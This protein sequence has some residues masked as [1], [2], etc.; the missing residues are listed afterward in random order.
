MPRCC[1]ALAATAA[2]CALAPMPASAALRLRPC[3]PGTARQC[4]RLTVPLDRSG[5]VP[6]TV[7][8]AVRRVRPAA[9]RSRGVV[10]ALAGGPGQ[11]AIPFTGQ[12][13]ALLGPV[14]GRRDL[15]VFDQ[16]GTGQSGLLRCRGVERG[17]GPRAYAAC[18]AALGPRRAAY[19]S[20]ESADDIEAI[21]RALGVPKITLYG[22]SYGT[23]V[24]EG[25]ALRHP[26]HVERLILDSVVTPDGPDPFQESTFAGIR[27]VV[28]RV[29]RGQSCPALGVSPVRDV[30][31]LLRRVRARPI[32]ATAVNGRGRRVPVRIREDDVLNVIVEGDLNP[33][34]RADLPPGLRSALSGD[35]AQLARAVLIARGAPFAPADESSALFAATVC[36]EQ[37]QPWPRGA[38]L[39]GRTRTAVA[40]INAEPAS[41]FVPFSRRAAFAAS[42]PSA[43]RAWPEAPEA[44]A[45]GG[46][47]FPDVPALVLGGSEDVRTPVEDA[48]RVA[49]QLPGAQLLEVPWVGHSTLSADASGCVQR[50]LGA[51]A[52]G[53]R[54]PRCRP[55]GPDIP[56]RGEVPTSLDATRAFAGVP[57]RAGRTLLAAVVTYL[58]GV[59]HA[60]YGPPRGG[61]LRGGTYRARPDGAVVLDRLSSIP[62]VTVSGTVAGPGAELRIGGSAAAR[63]TIDLQPT[64]RIV[65]VLGGRTIV[66]P[67]GRAAAASAGTGLRLARLPHR[68][69]WQPVR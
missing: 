34:L 63:G 55:R 20:K 43:C 57:G 29:C 61:G 14:I 52:R 69:R 24:A 42:V 30:Q 36:E 41:T 60:A 39:A 38:P 10:M 49:A 59:E 48:R 68:P 56:I 4:G 64:G 17:G 13:L 15:V 32:A 26:A 44:P 37:I 22:V 40:A 53:R 21:R 51:F 28:E 6:G 12:S 25:Y 18:A 23:K 11:A 8:L 50:A 46:S 19:T 54:A 33:A 31:A 5:A 9:G 27:R 47:G 58:D 62:G 45:F 66:V 3:A 16:R 1:R 67:A 35:P 7:S 2:L 65:A